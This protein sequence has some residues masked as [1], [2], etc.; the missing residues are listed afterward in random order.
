MPVD[1]AT[2]QSK[3]Y[4]FVEFG[5]A[6]EAAAAQQQTEGY[7]L[8]KAHVFKARRAAWRCVAR[9]ARCASPGLARRSN[10]RR[11]CQP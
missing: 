7:K 4:A 6:A 1:E 10:A 11:A 5:S 9:R 8:D 2:K 3:G